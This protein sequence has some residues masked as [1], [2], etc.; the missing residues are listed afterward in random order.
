MTQEKDIC[1]NGG[2]V[3]LEHKNEDRLTSS[4]KAWLEF[5]KGDK[6]K[7]ETLEHAPNIYRVVDAALTSSREGRKGV[8]V[9]KYVPRFGLLR[10]IRLHL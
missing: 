1:L 8:V 6:G 3:K 10:D 5:A 2:P 7:Y 9:C 4:G